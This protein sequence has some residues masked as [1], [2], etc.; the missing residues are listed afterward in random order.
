MSLA[1]SD[2]VEVEDHTHLSSPS[3]SAA[4]SSCDLKQQQQGENVEKDEWEQVG[5][6]NKST[7]TRQVSCCCCCCCRCCCCHLY[8]VTKGCV[9]EEQFVVICSLSIL[10]LIDLFKLQWNLQTTITLVGTIIL[11]FSSEVI[12]Y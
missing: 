10:V 2:V 7:I 12:K 5:P 1:A 8:V 6:K 4:S 3:L 11:L 9:R